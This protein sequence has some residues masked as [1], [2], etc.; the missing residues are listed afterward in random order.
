MALTL[1]RKEQARS[2]SPSNASMRIERR[3]GPAARQ[4]G[5]EE[6]AMGCMT[7]RVQNATWALALI[8]PVALSKHPGRAQDGAV[9]LRHESFLGWTDA[10]R[11]SNGRVTATV[12]PSAGGRVLEFSLDG[13][14]AFWVNPALQG[15]LF[16]VPK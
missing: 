6:A 8:A 3:P 13:Q 9:T 1:R 16:P 15:M 7:A 11:L 12:V 4:G 2:R 14:Q 10:Y 5:Q